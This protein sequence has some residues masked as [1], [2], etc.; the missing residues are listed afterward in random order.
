MLILEKTKNGNEVGK[1]KEISEKAR[2]LFP[3]RKAKKKKKWNETENKKRQGKLH[4]NKFGVLENVNKNDF[5]NLI[6]QEKMV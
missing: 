3:K 4:N 2:E 5:R 6:L 1:K